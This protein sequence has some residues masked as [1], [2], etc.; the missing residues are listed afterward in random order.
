[1]DDE[2]VSRL[3][4]IFEPYWTERRQ[5][6]VK[7]KGR[8]VHYTSA[9]SAIKI[10]QTKSIWMR[11]A[12]CMNDYN[13]IA[14]GFTLLR[15]LLHEP[16]IGKS[17]EGA[18]DGLKKGTLH[19]VFSAFDYWWNNIQSN[20][21][22][23]SISEHDDSEDRHGRLS[24]W[25]AYG[26][27]SA[28]AAVVINAPFEPRNAAKGLSLFLRP[29]LY[30][31]EDL[32]RREIM[33]VINDI[34]ENTAFLST[35]KPQIIAGQ[36][37]VWLLLTTVCLKHDGF[38]EEREWRVICLPKLRSSKFI[39]SNIE[40]VQGIP[41][42]VY[43]MPLQEVPDEDIVGISIP[44]LVERIIIGPTEYPYPLSNAFI[45]ELEKAGVKDAASRVILSGIPLRT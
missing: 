23:C 40:T 16:D 8:F 4:S 19:E 14:H 9:D 31:T 17:L 3:S 36:V 35:L 41:Q 45:L 43:K 44:Q 25:R 24:M 37:F 18:I 7:S 28:K 34:E 5:S 12:R 15:K 32:L 39:L 27:Q 26:Q 42:L 38:K 22:I 20:T 29:A 21:F 1:M 2:T 13:E 30:F 33:R 11:N 10:I 6:L